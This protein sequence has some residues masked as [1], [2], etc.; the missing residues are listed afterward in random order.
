MLKKSFGFSGII[1]AF[2]MFVIFISG[3]GALD[4][5]DDMKSTTAHMD[6]TTDD[7]SK[8]TQDLNKKTDELDK[9]TGEVDENVKHTSNTTDDLKQI[10][11]NMFDDFLNVHIQGR[12]GNSWTIRADAWRYMNA[13]PQ[14][15]GKISWAAGFFEAMENQ[16]WIDHF[17]DDKQRL[18]KLNKDAVDQ[19][20]RLSFAEIDKLHSRWF[21]D[22]FETN[23]FDHDNQ[24][25]NLFA[26][27]VTMHLINPDEE[28]LYAEHKLQKISMMDLLKTALASEKE[29]NQKGPAAFPEYVKEVLQLKPAAIYLLRLRANFLAGMAF[30]KMAKLDDRNNIVQDV[31]GL[32]D[33]LLGWTA[34]L[35][36]RNLAEIGMYLDW[37]KEANKTCS[38]IHQHLGSCDIDAKLQTLYRKMWIRSGKNGGEW[39]PLMEK[40]VAD[41]K[42]EMKTFLAAAKN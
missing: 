37:M 21:H 15:V 25:K 38:W 7:M 6:K 14:V 33:M 22:R 24:A 35:S 13:E 29:Y 11:Q 20:L 32:K 8:N 27:A 10:S 23:P 36:H 41:L 2:A 19:F 17:F 18:E 5:M 4:T 31:N 34:T 1:F 28:R 40:A 42:T 3:C 12:K 9:K 26:A 39:T 16:L 30:G